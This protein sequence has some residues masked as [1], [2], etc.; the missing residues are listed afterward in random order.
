MAP[1]KGKHFFLETHGIT[2]RADLFLNGRQLATKSFQSGSYG[3]HVYDV[4]PVLGVENVLLVQ[5]YPTD[6]RHDLAQAFIDWNQ[7]PPDR[8]AGVWRNVTMKQTGPVVLGPLSVATKF[9]TPDLAE[10]QVSFQAAVRNLENR[11]VTVEPS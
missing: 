7:S 6:H 4:T 2:P 1:G 11:T 8:G 3:G 5:V 10:V 9:L